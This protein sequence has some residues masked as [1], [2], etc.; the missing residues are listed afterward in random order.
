MIDDEL[1]NPDNRPKKKNTT[2]KCSSRMISSKEKESNEYD[3]D[4]ICEGERTNLGGL[5]NLSTSL[6]ILTSMLTLG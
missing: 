3:L 4:S 5:I 2:L 1:P 6:G